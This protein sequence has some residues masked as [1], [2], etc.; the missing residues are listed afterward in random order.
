MFIFQGDS[1]GEEDLLNLGSCSDSLQ[2]KEQREVTCHGDPVKI[3]KSD[4]K[5]QTRSIK[6]F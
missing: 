2:I 6:L 3:D 5:L 4:N 1:R